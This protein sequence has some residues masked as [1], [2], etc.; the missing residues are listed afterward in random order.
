ML[1]EN[2]DEF[3][4]EY[5]RLKKKFLSLDDDFGL[6]IKIIEK[7]PVGRGEKHWNKLFESENVFVLKSRLMC[8]YLKKKSLRVIYS[9]NE[10]EQK[11]LFVEIYFKGDKKKI[12]D[13]KRWKGV[14]IKN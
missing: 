3:N 11:I 6:F 12:E 13:T 7:Y 2:L 1:F 9:Y 10:K 4:K 5:K 14:V 8:R